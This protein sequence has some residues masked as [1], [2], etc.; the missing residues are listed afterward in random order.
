MSEFSHHGKP[1]YTSYLTFNDDVAAEN[2]DFLLKCYQ[3]LG[4]RAAARRRSS[5]A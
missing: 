5:A 3:A 1:D 4:D 2:I